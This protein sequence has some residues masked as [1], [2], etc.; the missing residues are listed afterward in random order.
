MATNIKSVNNLKTEFLEYLEIEKNRSVKTLNNYDRYLRRF[1]NWLKEYLKVKDIT[2]SHITEDNIRK[3][4]LYLNRTTDEKG[5]PLKKITQDYHV[6]ALRGFLKFLN[7]RDI[8]APPPEKIELGKT[9]RKEIEFLD[10]SEVERLLESPKGESLESLR[11][12]A[13]LEMLFA[14]GLRVSEIAGLNR[15]HFQIKK[16]EFTVEGKGNKRRIV[17]LSS[18]AQKAI[19]AYLQKRRDTDPALFIRHHGA[20]KTDSLRI[21][22]R[23]IQRIVKKHAL[24]AGITKDI[25]P[26]T[27]RHSFATDLLRNGADIRAVQALLG[28]SSIGTTQV[29]THVTDK[30]LREVH[31]DYHRKKN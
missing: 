26:H 24:R 30:H 10:K 11:D 19:Y 2:L 9:H 20:R 3:Y 22:V 8:Q 28:H 14:A 16:N 21:S 1:F 15:E 7:K 13:I 17:F 23:T 5:N 12:K 31:R 25:H 29:Y 4:R 6:I 27:L 18:S